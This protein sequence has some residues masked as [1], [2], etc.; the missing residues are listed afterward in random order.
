LRP[1]RRGAAGALSVALAASPACAQQPPDATAARVHFDRGVA[2][3]E[4]GDARGALAEFQRAYDLS[5]R[6]SVLYNIGASYQALHDYPSAIAAL[7]RFLAESDGRASAQRELA[8]RALLQMEPLVAL[9]RVA[10]SPADATVTLDGRAVTGDRVSVSPGAHTLVASAPGHEPRRLEVTVAS[11]DDREVSLSLTALVAVVRVPP[12]ADARR[13]AGDPRWVW[14]AAIT[15]GALAVGATITGALAVGAQHD[16]AS[17]RADD[18]E[19]ASLASRGRALALTADVLAV[20]AVGAGA[21]AL[22]LALLH[23]DRRDAPTVR[24]D[25]TPRSAV[26]A[27]SGSF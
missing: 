11:G 8:S 9:L 2:L 1:L 3:Y 10:R 24:L 20:G 25:A 27:V 15:G 6:A 16:Y 19:V 4:S 22:V 17:R 21:T 12:R 7:R 5:G 18:P 14:A 13:G 26:V 23:R